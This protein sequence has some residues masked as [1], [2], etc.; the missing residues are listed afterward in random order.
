MTLLPLVL[1]GDRFALSPA[2][3]GGC[4]ALQAI[5]SVLGATP[6]AAL[7]DRVGPSNVIAPALAVT[8]GSMMAFSCAHTLPQALPVLC[9][10]AA[11][12]TILGSAP[13][14]HA[15]NLVAPELRAQALAVMRTVGDLGLFVGATGVGITATL[16]GSDTAM[17][18]TSAFL[19]GSAAAYLL[20]ARLPL[21]FSR[22]VHRP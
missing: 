1:A 9:V 13:T 18:G 21:F 4:F 12:G 10:W 5:I 3:V 6:A 2:E 14:A 11:G 15:T 20:R 7:A 16:L 17:Q 19:F 22:G 8:A